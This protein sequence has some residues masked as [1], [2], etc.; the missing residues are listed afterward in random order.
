MLKKPDPPRRRWDPLPLLII[1]F[2][3]IVVY[4]LMWLAF[5]SD[6]TISP[7]IVP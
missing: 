7:S 6:V 1:L 2:G 3:W 5:R 4:G